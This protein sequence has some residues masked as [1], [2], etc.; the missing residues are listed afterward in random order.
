MQ[1][2]AVN[3]GVRFEQLIFCK[4]SIALTLIS[5]R[6]FLLLRDSALLILDHGMFRKFNSIMLT[7]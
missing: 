1:L 2:I 5:Q 6:Q 4:A 7:K 3:C